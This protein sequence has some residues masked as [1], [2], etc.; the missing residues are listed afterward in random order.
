[1]LRSVTDVHD[2]TFCGTST[3]SAAADE[4]IPE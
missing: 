1:M 4:V 3:S 2:S